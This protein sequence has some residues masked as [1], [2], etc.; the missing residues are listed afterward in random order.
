[1]PPLRHD[2]CG[3]RGDVLH[4]SPHLYLITTLLTYLY[5]TTI[6]LTAGDDTPARGLARRLD[7]CCL[8]GDDASHLAPPLLHITHIGPSTRLHNYTTGRW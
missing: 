4:T 7:D 6:L 3:L 5:N 2:E 8:R 1:M